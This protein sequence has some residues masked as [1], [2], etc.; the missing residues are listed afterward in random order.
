MYPSRM[1]VHLYIAPSFDDTDEYLAYDSKI[2]V[3]N[4]MSIEIPHLVVKHYINRLLHKKEVPYDIEQ[5]FENLFIE[6]QN[7]PRVNDHT[8]Q[9]YL[10]EMSSDDYYAML[11]RIMENKEECNAMFTCWTQR[12]PE[13]DTLVCVADSDLCASFILSRFPPVEM[14]MRMDIERDRKS[15]HM[16][17]GTGTS[18]GTG[19]SNSYNENGCISGGGGGGCDE[20]ECG[21]CEDCLTYRDD[22]DDL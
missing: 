8:R 15:L 13:M 20:D 19:I 12:R 3:N 18:T 11:R 5:H 16:D 2:V 14:Y 17:S 1:N 4:D 21:D 9:N 22:P 10:T 7:G 6:E